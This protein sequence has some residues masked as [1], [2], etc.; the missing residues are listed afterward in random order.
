M[1]E[2]NPTSEGH[3]PRRYPAHLNGHVHRAEPAPL[4]EPLPQPPR[5]EQRVFRARYTTIAVGVWLSLSAFLFSHVDLT[6]THTWIVGFLVV[7]AGLFTI[8][9]PVARPLNTTLA[10]WLVATTL[11]F[12][13]G[14]ELTF[15]HNIGVGLVL[16]MLSVLPNRVRTVQIGR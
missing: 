2:R 11:I 12:F 6:R 4:A 14:S 7:L 1:T 5:V 16:F 15:W 13:P 10:V 3:A 9:Y 8:R